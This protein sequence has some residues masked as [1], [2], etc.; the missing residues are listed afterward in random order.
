M[1]N[2]AVPADDRRSS[3]SIRQPDPPGLWVAD[4]RERFA[5]SVQAVDLLAHGAADV[6]DVNIDSG[7]TDF[8]S[9]AAKPGA[10]IDQIIEEAFE[11][12]P[13]IPEDGATRAPMARHAP[14]EKALP[15]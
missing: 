10:L 13:P 4:I 9:V 8:A 5:S 11:D 12:P 1:P 2:A 6:A 7:D 15:R 14:F 3:R